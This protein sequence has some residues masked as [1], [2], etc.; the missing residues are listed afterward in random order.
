M[1]FQYNPAFLVIRA[2]AEGP[3]S[4]GTAVTRQSTCTKQQPGSYKCTEWIKPTVN[5]QPPPYSLKEVP[6]PSSKGYFHATDRQARCEFEKMV[7]ANT[8][9]VKAY[10]FPQN[11]TAVRRNMFSQSNKCQA[12]F[13]STEHRQTFRVRILAL[14]HTKDL[15]HNGVQIILT[16][17]F[18]SRWCQLQMHRTF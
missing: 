7:M 10:V 17:I 2:D 4:F 18:S 16:H 15:S 12:G 6:S 5:R 1:V 11:A 8:R 14:S 9:V 3:K 13:R